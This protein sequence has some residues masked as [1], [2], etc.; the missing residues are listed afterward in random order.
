MKLKQI[1]FNF[2]YINLQAEKKFK[3]RDLIVQTFLDATPSLQI[4]SAPPK[5]PPGALSSSEDKTFHRAV[6]TLQPSALDAFF[7][8]VMLCKYSGKLLRLEPGALF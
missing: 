2:A 1:P 5:T 6:W 4:P 8:S 7:N 3:A